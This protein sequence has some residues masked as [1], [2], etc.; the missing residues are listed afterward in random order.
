[1]SYNSGFN[2]DIEIDFI[3]VYSKIVVLSVADHSLMLI[4]GEFRMIF[5]RQVKIIYSHC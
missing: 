2:T 5:W 3:P 4:S 1:M